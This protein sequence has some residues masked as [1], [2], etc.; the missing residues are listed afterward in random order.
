M[1]LQGNEFLPC[2]LVINEGRAA[3]IENSSFVIYECFVQLTSCPD[4][5]GKGI[6][7]IIPVMKKQELHFLTCHHL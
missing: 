2:S 1:R 5:S 4:S 3:E 6:I 7:Q